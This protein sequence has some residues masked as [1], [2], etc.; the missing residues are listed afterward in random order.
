MQVFL[1]KKIIIFLGALRE[2]DSMLVERI[3]I[4][5]DKRGENLKLVAQRLGFSENA[6]YKWNTQSPKTENL[7]KVADYF[8]VSID[9]LLGRTEGEF[10]QD[11]IGK[12]EES[13]DPDIRTLQ[14]AASKMTADERKKAIKILEAAFD[15]LFDDED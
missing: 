8:N 6:L 13:N 14:R 4:L 2:V 5:A 3:K 10:H 11:L 12:E 7:E 9:Y 1:S 15:D